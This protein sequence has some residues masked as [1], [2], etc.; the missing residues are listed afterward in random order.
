MICP[1]CGAWT[2]ILS[3]RQSE[4]FGTMRRHECANMHRFTTQEV[5][6]PEEVMQE[7]KRE[8]MLKA[9]EKARAAK[10]KRR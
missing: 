5:V 7:F 9:A 1:K 2:V 8:S 4:R 6:I 10:K 3:S